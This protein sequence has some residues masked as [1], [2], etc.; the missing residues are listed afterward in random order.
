VTTAED[1]EFEGKELE[2]VD[3]G[4]EPEN[5]IYRNR[6]MALEDYTLAFNLL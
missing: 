5:N 2:N 6:R 1:L 4:Y 3:D